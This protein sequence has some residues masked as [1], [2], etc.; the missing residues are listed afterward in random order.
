MSRIIGMLIAALIV[1]V[2]PAAAQSF[3]VTPE[4]EM[5]VGERP[6]DL[7]RN[8]VYVPRKGYEL[9]HV[10]N[11]SDDCVFWEAPTDTVYERSV[12]AAWVLWTAALALLG[13]GACVL[14]GTAIFLLLRDMLGKTRKTPRAERGGVVASTTD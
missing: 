11:Y 12:Y 7:Q 9:R 3:R 1:G 4:H 6:V 2:A 14:I 8:R 5:A 13:L 10:C